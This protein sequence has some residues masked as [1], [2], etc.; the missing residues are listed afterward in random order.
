MMYVL[1][2]NVVSELRKIRAGKADPKVAAWAESVEATD[3]FVSAITIMELELGVLLIE[4]KDATQGAMLRAWLE[5]HVL[6]EFAGRTLPVDTAVAQRCARLHVPDKCS[7]R[8]A[9]IAATAL[10]HGMTVVTRNVADFRSTGVTI[11][12][13]WESNP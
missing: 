5:Q 13:P 10:V 2:T 3:L 4:R 6:P 12:N 9:L 1:D 7:E 11:L 8:D